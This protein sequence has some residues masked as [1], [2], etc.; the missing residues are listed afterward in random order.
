MLTETVTETK[1]YLYQGCFEIEGD[2]FSKAGIAS[3]SI[4][5]GLKKIGISGDLI[6]RAAIVSYESEVNI[7]CH[8][9]KGVISVKVSPNTIEIEAVDEGPGIADIELAM[10]E[11]YSTA[12]HHIR[13]MGF[14]AGMGLPNMKKYSDNLNISS[15][16]GK[17]TIIKATISIL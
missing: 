9:I 15:E 12:D 16:V 13:E 7:V 11:G 4:K 8:A 1:D 10:Q 3:T 2:N 6:K 17:G 5:S 14:G